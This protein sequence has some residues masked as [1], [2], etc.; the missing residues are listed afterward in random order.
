MYLPGFPPI[1]GQAGAGA[2]Q[3]FAAVLDAAN[4]LATAD[5]AEGDEDGAEE[6]GEEVTELLGRLMFLTPLAASGVSCIKDRPALTGLPLGT[7]GQAV[8]QQV[9]RGCAPR[10]CAPHGGAPRGAGVTTEDFKRFLDRL[11]S[12]C[13]RGRFTF[14]S[15]LHR[16]TCLT[17]GQGILHPVE[18]SAGLW[19][20]FP[21][22][23]TRG[24]P[25]KRI[26]GCYFVVIIFWIHFW[27][28]QGK[29]RALSQIHRDLSSP[30]SQW[31]S[32]N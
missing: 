17:V 13:G 11:P 18:C 30:S 21:T 14:R 10:G 32:V 31:I 9:P 7:T 16:Y 25:A 12:F 20:Y 6:K 26:P 15:D 28:K 22:D 3:G 5:A 24:R 29:L 8:S 23:Q 27:V 19:K 1:P 2:D 4:K